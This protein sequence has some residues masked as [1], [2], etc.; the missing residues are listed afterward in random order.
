MSCEHGFSTYTSLPDWQAQMVWSVV[1]V[2]RGDRNRVDGFVVEQFSIIAIAGGTASGGL[3]DLAEARVED[4]FVDVADGRDLDVG[5]PG[6]R[7]NV[8]ASASA[9]SDAGDTDGVAGAGHGT[10]SQQCARGGCAA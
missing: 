2:R 4:G 3:L 10:G 5:H 6:V 7:A 9:H 8:V 1:M